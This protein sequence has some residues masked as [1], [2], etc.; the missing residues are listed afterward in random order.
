MTV[1]AYD[2]SKK[3]L[4]KDIQPQ[5]GTE[6]PSPISILYPVDLDRNKNIEVIGLNS[7]TN[8]KAIDLLSS[9]VGGKMDKEGKDEVKEYW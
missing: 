1:C 3:I 6:E 7:G 8:Q 4:D 5:A 2:Y 9:I